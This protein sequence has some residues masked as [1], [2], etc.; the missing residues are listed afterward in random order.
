VVGDGEDER[1]RRECNSEGEK[2]R[3]SSSAG[4]VSSSDTETRFPGE[5]EDGATE[6]RRARRALPWPGGSLA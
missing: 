3:E 5:E 6:R 1:G 2:G 4:A